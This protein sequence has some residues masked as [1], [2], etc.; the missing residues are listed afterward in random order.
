[1]P[2]DQITFRTDPRLKS[3]IADLVERGE[4]K[5]MS[6]FLNQAIL[7]KFHL[8]LVPIEGEPPSTDPMVVFF[9]SPRGRALLAEIVRAA[10][11]S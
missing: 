2:E 8:D 7:Q 5:T 9:E 1:M 11:E 3:R 6:D 10:R 4:Y